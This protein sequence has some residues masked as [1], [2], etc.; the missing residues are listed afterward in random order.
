MRTMTDLWTLTELRQSLGLQSASDCSQD[1]AVTGV[2]I[3]TRA[4]QPGDLFVALS[5]DA[6]PPFHSSDGAGRDGHEFLQVAFARGA[7]A[8][9]I[10]EPEMVAGTNGACIAVEDTFNGLWTLARSAR[11]R[12]GAT[13]C[14]L[15]G[16]SGKTTLRHMLGEL[17]AV[18]GD[19]HTSTGS[20]NNHWG[21]PLSMA[22]MPRS[23]AR[24]AFEV[25]MNHPG[26]IA[27][28]AELVAPDIAVVLNVLPVHLEQFQDGL[29]GI[30][31]EKL[32][33]ARGL[34]A[35]GIL[36]VPAAV[37]HSGSN[38]IV[39]DGQEGPVVLRQASH[40]KLTFDYRG[41]RLQVAAPEAGPHHIQTMAAALT[42]A[43]LMD[44]PADAVESVWAN[45]PSL[46]GRGALS[47]RSGVTVCDDSY[48]ANP[49]SMGHALDALRSRAGTRRI[50]VLGEMLELGNAAAELH[51]TLTE[52]TGGLDGV[53]T[54]G[55]GLASLELQ[56]PLWG[57]V[58]SVAELAPE[59]FADRLE[60]GDQ[61]L[62]K[63]SNRV[64]WVHGWVAGLL[65]VLAA[66]G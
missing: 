35:S 52:A 30:R 48:N 4:L 29:V 43:A 7:A 18:E 41:H 27:P 16:S 14:A 17:F 26:E 47:T 8:A 53:I 46:A 42:V 62:V 1:I 15:T 56:S 40:D 59:D 66:R 24:A 5:G 50:A 20:L 36:L 45:L 64:F 51:S 38:V 9:L 25:G 19:G 22:R 33:I 23:A 54:V 28:L 31:R 37:A 32:S 34:N 11:A 58:D 3:D 65:Q 55:P 39:Y 21:V 61:V 6:P 60:P 2:S 13:V 49:I 63:G 57:H 44:L 10:H 12:T